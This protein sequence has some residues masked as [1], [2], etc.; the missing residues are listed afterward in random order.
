VFPRLLT[1][2][3]TFTQPFLVQSVTEYLSSDE[4]YPYLGY[5]LIGAYGFVYT[6]LAVRAMLFPI[7]ENLH[8]ANALLDHKRMVLA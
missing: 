3:F 2:A 7:Y 4:K 1:S 6:G 8:S 5:G